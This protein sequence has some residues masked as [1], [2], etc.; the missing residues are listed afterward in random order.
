[1]SDDPLY[2]YTQEIL[3]MLRACVEHIQAGQ[4]LFYRPA[5]V[6]LRML[7]CDTTRRHG[8]IVDISLLP[9]V[10]PRLSLP[11]LGEAPDGDRRPLET[12][13]EQSLPTQPPLSVR[14][15]IRRVC[16]QDGGA[17]VDLKPQR[18]PPAQEACAAW[19]LAIARV[20]LAEM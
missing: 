1:M 11:L 4:A 6:Q 18:L 8:Q 12:W 13:L 17:H 2:T 16:D 14:Q 7:L 9:Q 19:I 10:S 5:A 15:L 3:G 20:I